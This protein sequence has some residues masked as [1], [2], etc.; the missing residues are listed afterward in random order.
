MNE[1]AD[2]LVLESSFRILIVIPTLGERLDTL[3]RTLTSIQSQTKV[4]VDILIVTKT[5]TLALCELAARHGSQ[6]M[7]HPGNIS[8]AVNAGFAQAT[9]KHRYVGWLGDDDLLRP[10]ALSYSSRALE[11]NPTAVVA[12]GDCDYIN[13]NGDLMFCRRPPPMALLLL[14]M[15]PGLIKQEACLFRLQAVQQVQGL[16]EKLRYTMDLDILL[17]LRK[18]GPFLRVNKVLAAFCWHA[19]SITVS[20]RSLSLAEAQDVQRRH[21]VGLLRILT[22]L[23]MP[24]IRLLILLM[25]WKINR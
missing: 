24:P 23:W 15:I 7:I 4:L 20:N 25:S 1:T 13:I 19:G 17:K 18:V 8:M 10:V 2:D 14:Q 9:E 12:Y 11:Q 5:Q 21:A 16:D 3:S 22:P 6:I